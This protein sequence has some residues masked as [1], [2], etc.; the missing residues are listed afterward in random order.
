[1]ST[2]ADTVRR[3]PVCGTDNPPLNVTC[4]NCGGYIRE[5]IASLHLFQTLGMLIETPTTAMQRIIVARQKNYSIVLQ[6]MFGLA[7]TAFVFWFAN[8]GLLI[9]DLQIILLFILILGPVTGIVIVSVLAIFTTLGV[10]VRHTRVEVRD[11]RAVLSYATFPI[12]MSVMFIFPVEVGVFGMY[13]FTGTP[14]PFSINPLVYVLFLGLDGVLIIWSLLLVFIGIRTLSGSIA[15][16]LFIKGI[17]LLGALL[18][19][20]AVNSIILLY[21]SLT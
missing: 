21:A 2:R 12:I 17:I 20:I 11:V 10:R 9:N 1:M 8:I 5:R 15:T 6:M 19:A 4:S 18:P 13:L 16:A 14:S 7:Y 3:C